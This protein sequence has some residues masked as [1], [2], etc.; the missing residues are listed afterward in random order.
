M[1][2]LI[3]I[4]FSTPSFWLLVRV[5]QDG[6]L[7]LCFWAWPEV[8]VLGAAQGS[9]SFVSVPNLA[10]QKKNIYLEV[11]VTKGLILLS[12]MSLKLQ[13]LHLQYVSTE[14]IPYKILLFFATVI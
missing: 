13:I 14:R 11:V 1:F 12:K 8:E 9:L 10:L 4:L 7:L 2:L 5:S 3:L 6:L